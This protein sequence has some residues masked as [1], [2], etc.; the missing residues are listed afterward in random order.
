M[1]NI[2]VYTGPMKCGKTKRAIEAATIQKIRGKEIKVFKPGIDNRFAD[3]KIVTRF[4]K[5]L[6]TLNISKIE[7]IEKYDAD[8]YIID[9]FQF[10]DGDIEAINRLANKDKK[11]Y[12]SGLNLTSDKKPFGRMGEIMC[13]ADKI[14]LMTSVCEVC[15]SEDAIYTYYSGPKDSD[16]LVGE[17]GYMPVCRE[18]YEKLS[19]SNMINSQEEANKTINCI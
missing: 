14:E 7:D 2:N 1:G 8:V 15:K 19:L 10:L 6:D 9:E 17:A 18:C 12:I 3:S 11:I 5:E 13:M 4:G 16:I